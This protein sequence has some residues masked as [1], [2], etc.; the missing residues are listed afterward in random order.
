MKRILNKIRKRF[1]P[2][3]TVPPFSKEDL[4]ELIKSIGGFQMQPSKYFMSHQTYADIKAS[5]YSGAFGVPSL[6]RNRSYEK[7]SGATQG[8]SEEES[9]DS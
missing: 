9:E 4:D 1:S 3:S 8:G 6:Q 7:G 5:H 2:P